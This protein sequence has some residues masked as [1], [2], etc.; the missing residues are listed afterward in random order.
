MH[1]HTQRGMYTHTHAHAHTQ[2]HV[3]RYTYTEACIH[4]I[5]R[6]PIQVVAGVVVFLCL[7]HTLRREHLG[8]RE[9]LSHPLHELFGVRPG[10]QQRPRLGAQGGDILCHL[11]STAQHSTVLSAGY[12]TAQHSRYKSKR[13]TINRVDLRLT[14]NGIRKQLQMDLGIQYTTLC[15]TR[16]S[17]AYFC[18]VKSDQS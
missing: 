6:L 1:M 4:T 18:D 5:S 7:R 13:V 2:S 16:N 3:Y 10:G 8:L 9:G 15:E 12:I 14:A 17:I 11:L